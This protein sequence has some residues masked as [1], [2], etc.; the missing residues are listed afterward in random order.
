MVQVATPLDARTPARSTARGAWVVALGALAAGAAFALAWT[1][2]GFAA[3]THATGFNPL[4][5]AS[6]L[7]VGLLVGL[8]GVGGGSLMTPLLVLLFGFHPSTAVGTDLLYAAGTKSVGAS[9]HSSN[10]TIDWKVTGLLAAGSVPATIIAVLTLFMLGQ[11]GQPAQALISTILGF[12]LLLT[13]VTL[14]F[15]QRIFAF[16]ARRSIEFSP[17]TTAILTIALGAAL[18]GLITLSSVGAGALGVTVLVFLYPKMPMARIVGSDIAHAVPLT[19]I[20]GAGHFA[21][22]SV[23]LPLLGSLLVGSIPGIIVGSNL[24]ARIPERALRPVLAAT[25]ILVG[26]K[27]IF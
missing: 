10:R 18:G 27:L 2:G 17:R 20:A 25:L 11:N 22:G 16:A 6:G 4:Y 21:L 15:R 19:L 8:T 26:V 23:N 13:A 14:V 1:H 24:T 5:A 12:A 9:V 3:G 7:L